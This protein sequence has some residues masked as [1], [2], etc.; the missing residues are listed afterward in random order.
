MKAPP[1][2][3]GGIEVDASLRGV[4]VSVESL[5]SWIRGGIAF[6]TP[7]SPGQQVV[8]GHRFMLEPQ[9]LPEWLEWQ[10]RIAVGANGQTS[11]GLPHP[12]PVRV[13][14][15]WQASWLG[16]YRRRTA[17]CWG[18]A[19]DD[20]TLRVPATFLEAAAEPTSP[21]TIEVV[22]KSFEF[23]LQQS[24]IS[25][26]TGSLD[27]PSGTI[28]DPWKSKQCTENWNDQM[29]LLVINPEL[30]EPLAIDGTRV[31]PE[32]SGGLRL[33]PGVAVSSE[34]DGSPVVDAASGRLYGLIVD[35]G[36]EWMIGRL[37]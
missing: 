29:T 9:P 14:A 22:G 18:L 10:P 35:R 8:T 37:P 13:V 6:A 7:Q 33:A 34:L 3:I 19:M 36:S 2:V 30:S 32:P 11:S 20:G 17:E 5:S 23:E 16:L 31:S 1:S 4:Q 15:S 25:G 12:T 28:A 27:L 24:R 26:V 21:V